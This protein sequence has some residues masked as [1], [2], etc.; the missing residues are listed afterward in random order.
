MAE[1]GVRRTSTNSGLPGLATPSRGPRLH[2]CH[3]SSALEAAHNLHAPPQKVVSK[4]SG[5]VML[6]QVE[7]VSFNGVDVAVMRMS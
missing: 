6:S 1:V 2:L 7:E 3:A 4:L 5:T